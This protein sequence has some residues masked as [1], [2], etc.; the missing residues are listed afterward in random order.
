MHFSLQLLEWVAIG[1]CVLFLAWLGT[2]H[3]R[4]RRELERHVGGIAESLARVEPA[5]DAHQ[6]R[7]QHSPA[8]RA[9]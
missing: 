2:K 3:E 6:C 7:S 9:V 5:S 4:R 8:R 1:G